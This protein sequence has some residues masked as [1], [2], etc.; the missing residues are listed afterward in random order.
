MLSTDRR[1][2]EKRE[3]IAASVRHRESRLCRFGIIIYPAKMSSNTARSTIFA[4]ALT[5]SNKWHRMLR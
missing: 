2:K 3:E 4:A 5:T 1:V